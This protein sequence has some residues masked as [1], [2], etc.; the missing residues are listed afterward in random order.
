MTPKSLLIAA[1]IAGLATAA[2]AG[3]GRQTVKPEDHYEHLKTVWGGVYA[4]PEADRG[5]QAAATLCARC[6]GT[7]LKGAKAT[8]LTGTK[9]FDRWADL[10]LADVV[11]YIQ[12]AMPHE[13]EVF[14]SRDSTRDIVSFMLRES[15]V[16]AGRDAMTADLAAMNEIVITRP[17]RK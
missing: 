1:G 2:F 7:D 8:G 3:A 14:V 4:A 13:H 15:G 5:K 10:R 6:H 16:P 9:F 17:P 11:N 12:S